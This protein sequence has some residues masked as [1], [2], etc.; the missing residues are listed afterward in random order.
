M[1]TYLSAYTCHSAG[2]LYQM[3]EPVFIGQWA[4]GLRIEHIAHRR[5]CTRSEYSGRVIG[6]TVVLLSAVVGTSVFAT[7]ESSP[8]LGFR[9]GAGLLSIAAAVIAALQTFLK[10]DARAAG[11]RETSA[12]YGALRRELDQLRATDSPIGKAQL[13]AI[14]SR[15][16]EIDATAPPVPNR[17]HEAARSYVLGQK[18]GDPR[19]SQLDSRPSFTS[20]T[21]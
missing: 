13:A 6:S 15:W 16:D 8:S 10:F 1:Y 7:I 3:D 11:H 17:V 9:I 4:N 19:V 2:S 5:A 14:R 20:D 21:P 18:A 12:K